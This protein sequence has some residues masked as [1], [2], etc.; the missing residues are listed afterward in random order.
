M[1]WFFYVVYIS[2]PFLENNKDFIFK[3]KWNVKTSKMNMLKQ[4]R[5]QIQSYTIF[6]NGGKKIKYRK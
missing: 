5:L 4:L 1:W 3:V 2:N 6:L